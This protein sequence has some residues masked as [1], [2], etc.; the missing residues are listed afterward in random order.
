MK[1]LIMK[2]LRE[3][4]LHVALFLLAGLGSIL[5]LGL[6]KQLDHEIV[7]TLLFLFEA[8]LFTILLGH[9]LIQSEVKQGTFPSL[10]ALPVNRWHLWI[11][12]LMAAL[13]ICVL[14][15]GVF[16]GLAIMA[17]A[18]ACQ[19]DLGLGERAFW[20]VP[21]L[22][23]RGLPVFTPGLLLF[24]IPLVL[25]TASFWGSMQP[26][27][28]PAFEAI[29]GVVVIWLL[30][31]QRILAAMHLPLALGILTIAFLISSWFTFRR[32]ELLTDP[33]RVGRALLSLIVCLALGGGAWAILDQVADKR[34][35]AGR[36]DGRIQ[37]MDDGRGV[38]YTM[39]T[40]AEWFDPLQG[41]GI[42]TGDIN[43]PDQFDHFRCLSQE[44]G[45][46]IPRQIGRRGLT[47]PLLSPDGQTMAAVALTRAPG[48]RTAPRLVLAD[49]RTGAIHSTIDHQARPLAFLGT[50][51][52][53]LY[54]RY[55]HQ[56][57]DGGIATELCVHETGKSPRSI[58][59]AI[60]ERPFNL[61]ALY[62]PCLNRLLIQPPDRDSL[63]FLSPENGELA[64]SPFRGWNWI[65]K[66]WQDERLALILPESEEAWWAVEPGREPRALTEVATT[67]RF[68][69]RDAKGRLLCVLEVPAPEPHGLPEEVLGIFDPAT[70]RCQPLPENAALRLN[71]LICGLSR[72]GRYLMTCPASQSTGEGRVIELETRKEAKVTLPREVVT[73]IYSVARDG[74][75][76]FTERQAWRHD[77]E[78]AET[79]QIASF[80]EPMSFWTIESSLAT[81]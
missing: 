16:Y 15:Y 17:G 3:H 73:N 74:F 55:T 67:T 58:Y 23:T 21:W 46:T 29:I 44:Q 49:R 69:G 66:V 32:A 13:G 79:V 40:P 1:T 51:D 50:R 19:I 78:T 36:M 9:H 61:Q 20:I 60:D 54:L 18:P 48:I 70:H 77:P 64:S 28:V 7:L 65:R 68:L 25:L 11:G 4:G 22:Q 41:L 30:W 34:L 37:V 57:G 52:R 39:R 14:V 38:L 6:F 8:P 10:A 2:E 63:W 5:L 53:L 27:G 31:S 80:P 72:S 33:W 26:A 62:L 81:F 45:R 59:T 12:K 75:L 35:L 47:D 71:G 42:L 56:T 24:W 43:D 76:V